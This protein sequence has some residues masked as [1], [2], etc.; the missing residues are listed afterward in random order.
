MLAHN[1]NDTKAVRNRLS[2]KNCADTTN[3]FFSPKVNAHQTNKIDSPNSNYDCRIRPNNATAE[4]QSQLSRRSSLNRSLALTPLY[5]STEYIPVYANRATITNTISDDEKWKILSKKRSEM[6]SNGYNHLLSINYEKLDQTINGSTVLAVN[7]TNLCDDVYALYRPRDNSK[8]FTLPNT[9]EKINDDYTEKNV[10]NPQYRSI[11]INKDLY[12]Y[13]QLTKKQ[14][15][16]EKLGDTNKSVSKVIPTT[17]FCIQKSQTDGCITSRNIST[18]N[19]I[20]LSNCN[21]KNIAMN[22]AQIKCGTTIN[23]H[24]TDEGGSY[25]EGN[26]YFYNGFYFLNYVS[27]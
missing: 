12:L 17:S 4:S 3:S 16:K 25:I 18:E 22:A 21:N 8:Q 20:N 13:G 6:L 1:A 5:N 7:Q 15:D 23:I 10:L 26:K 14:C 2:Y 9:L 24:V 19:Q 11:K 27:C